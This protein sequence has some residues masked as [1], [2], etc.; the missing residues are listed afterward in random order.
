METL[1]LFL[2]VLAATVWVGGQ[3][4]L[5]ALVPALRAAGADVPKAAANAF[6]RIA[7]PA[8]GVLLLTG[9]WNVVAEGDKGPAYQRTLMLKYTLV[10]ASGVTAFVHA[11]ARSRRAMAVFGAL[12]GL[13]AVAALLVGILLAA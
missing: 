1:R 10:V 13:T 12:T 11:R 8:F 2:H 3:I 9:I 7:W 5:A 6:N 4:T